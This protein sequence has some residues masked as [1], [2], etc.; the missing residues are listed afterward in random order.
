[1]SK[2]IQYFYIFSKLTTSL[3]FFLIIII[4]GYI[5][6]RSYQG[7]DSEQNEIEVK[8]SSLDNKINK[9]YF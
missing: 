8:I 6:F 5:M 2:F 9:N 4:M 3:V 1:M 7:I